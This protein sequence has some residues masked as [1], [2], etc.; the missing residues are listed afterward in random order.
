VPERVLTQRRLNRALLARQLLLERARLPIP[1]VLEAVAGLQTQY[2]PA[3]Y[4]GLWSRLD[5][6]RRPA[7]T[8]GL[9][10][11]SVVQAT[12]MRATIHMVSAGDYWPFA[13]ATRPSRER[14]Y[15]R[16]ARPLLE[17]V[18]MDRAVR[19]LRAELSGGPLRQDEL[20]TRLEADGIP[21]TAWNGLAQLVHLVRV[22][23]SG[24]WEQ[25]RAN[26]YALAEDWLGLP[27]IDEP[28]AIV[29]LVRRYLAGFGPAAKADVVNWTG[30]TAAAL[31]PAFDALELR[32]FRDEDGRELLDLA[33]APLPDESTPSPV[34]F[35]PTW[36]ANL[37]VHARRTGILPE[38]YRPR[39]FNTKTPHSVPTFL[40]DG[41]VAGTWRYEAGRVQLE[42]FD[43]LPAAAR[44]DLD[45]EAERLAAWHEEAPS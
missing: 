27:A 43:D 12:V 19:R 33:C 26:R 17:G 37:L 45:D 18:D 34:R 29:H 40:V 9:V 10:D 28:E 16:A 23:P 8:E 1:A 38:P 4:L 39:I 15:L 3:G 32:R 2:A 20:V 11:R 42:V 25:R 24:T 31:T 6:F 22:P 13:V 7:L 14:W 41:A 35:L 21:R 5:G 36:D 30:L 44:R